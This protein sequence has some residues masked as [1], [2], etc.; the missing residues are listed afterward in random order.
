MAQVDATTEANTLKRR[1]TPHPQSPPEAPKRGLARRLIGMRRLRCPLDLSPLCSAWWKNQLSKQQL[2][3]KCNGGP[4]GLE[5]IAA[6]IGGEP[7]TIEDVTERYLIQ[8]GYLQRTP[9][10]TAWRRH[11]ASAGNRFA[12]P[13]APLGLKALPQVGRGA[14]AA[15]QG[16]RPVARRGNE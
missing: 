1:K 3:A 4:V 16:A 6:S 10:K 12:H 9:R 2:T 8:Q 14:R 11:A 7:D 5:H 13:A 15:V